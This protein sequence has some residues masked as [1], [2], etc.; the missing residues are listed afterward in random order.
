[1]FS[2]SWDRFITAKAVPSAVGR[3]RCAIAWR[4][5]QLGDDLRD[6]VYPKNI[7]MIG[8]T[9]CRAKNRDLAQACKSFAR[10]PFLNG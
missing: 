6:E 4:R 8:P 3:S 2:L 10:A 5:N 9:G 7:L 1:L